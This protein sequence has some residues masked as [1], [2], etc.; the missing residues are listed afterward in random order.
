MTK[1]GFIVDNLEPSQINVDLFK[2][3]T[4]SFLFTKE[5]TKSFTNI[6][7]SVMDITEIWN[8]NDGTLIAT[9]IDT[10]LFLQNSINNSKKI[11]FLYDYEEMKMRT[12][13]NRLCYLLSNDFI[14]IAVRSKFYANRFEKQFNRKVSYIWENFNECIRTEKQNVPN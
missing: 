3:T 11:L 4:E 10:G 14:H 5:L 7:M 12:D 8:F 2:S 6:E 13:G 9:S 1:T